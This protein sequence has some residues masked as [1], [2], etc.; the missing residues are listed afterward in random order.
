LIAALKSGQL[1]GTYLDV[2]EVEPLPQDSALWNLPNVLVTP[3][4]S[5]A[6][7]G[8]DQRVLE[9]FLDNLGRWHRSEELVNE[10][11]KQ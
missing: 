6:A 5:A 1:A 2:F 7:A 9:L 10:I 3:H 11:Q 4:N 8:N